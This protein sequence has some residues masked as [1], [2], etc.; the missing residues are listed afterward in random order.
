M[1]FRQGSSPLYPS[2]SISS[3][4]LSSAE[5]TRKEGKLKFNYSTKNTTEVCYHCF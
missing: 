2:V 4:S 5:L 1:K 3:P